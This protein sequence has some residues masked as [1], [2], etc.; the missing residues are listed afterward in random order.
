MSE[1]F[2]FFYEIM[3]LI[4]LGI[5]CWLFWHFALEHSLTLDLIKHNIKEIRRIIS[6]G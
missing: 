6:G 3:V 5:E 4:L 2:Q 1:A